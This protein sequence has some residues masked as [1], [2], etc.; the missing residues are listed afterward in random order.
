M[1][2]I[3]L[4]SYDYPKNNNVFK[5]TLVISAFLSMIFLDQT[6]VGVT[7][8]TIQKQLL[9]SSST[10]AWIMNIYMIALSA[11][12]LLFAR[13]SDSVGIKNIFCAGILLF[14]LASLG[15]A[16]SNSAAELIISRGL[17]GIGASM[18]YATYLLIF[19]YQVPQKDRGKVLGTSAAFAA[20]FLALGP[21]I[22][23]FFSTIMSWRCLFWF[24]VPICLFCFY[25]AISACKKHCH[26]PHF[27]L[28]DKVG[29]FYYLIFLMG[30]IV[31]LMEGS[32]LGWI[33]SYI[34]MAL[35]ISAIF[36]ILF[37]YHEKRHSQPLIELSLFKNKI[38][39][40]GVIILFFNYAC[41]TS[42]VFWPLWLEQVLSYSPLLAGIALL[43]VGMP[44]I[45]TSRLG[46][47]LYDRYGARLPLLIGSSL[48]LFGLLEMALAVMSLQY[49]WFMIG[50]LL[51]GLGWG[52]VRPCAILL[53]LNSVDPS[54]KSMATGV[55]ST[56][57]QLGA[58]VGFALVYA[59][60]STYQHFSLLNIIRQHKLNISTNQLSFFMDHIHHYPSLVYLVSSVN[61][62]HTQG[63]SL[64]LFIIS[65][66]AMINLI[67]VIKYL[68]SRAVK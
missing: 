68:K 12:L 32:T 60:I 20:I 26:S 33:S 24:N 64:G 31:F 34:L 6:A 8:A 66:L 27:V 9:L 55:I 11:F 1:Q 50:M 21:L 16:V 65:L 4:S 29:L 51:I 14:M 46:G 47:A 61:T 17:Q 5:I 53:S 57:R 42:M 48:F 49:L 38:F 58:A 62:V 2:V 56:M 39:C 41:V 63:L 43:P 10:I 45:V 28:A 13:L 15:C 22:G 35:I 3:D 40:T 25:F 30:F 52:F 59:V 36:F 44:Y 18:G 67:L 23:G 54:Q 19:N 7:L 37:I